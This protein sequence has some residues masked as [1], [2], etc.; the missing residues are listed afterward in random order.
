MK[1][2][3][4]IYLRLML[5]ALAWGT[6]FTSRAQVSYSTVSL[7]ASSFTAD[8]I[9]NGSASVAPGSVPTTGTNLP[10]DG[11][12]S[13]NYYY[14]S[15]DYNSSVG[16]HTAGLPNSGL[17]PNSLAG[18][19]ALTYQLAPYTGNNSL[20][21]VGS[22]TPTS[23]T[24][25][26]A[27]PTAAAEVYVLGVSGNGSSTA[28]MT[29]NY[30]DGTSTT[31]TNQSVPD[32]YNTSASTVPAA[33]VFGVTVR[34]NSNTAYTTAAA[35]TAPF[36][37]QIKLTIP[38]N[39]VTT[40]ITGVTFRNTTTST[41]VVMN[42][43]AIS[44]GTYPVCTVAPATQA[45]ATTTSGGSTALTTAC[46]STSI[47][48]S[49]TGMPVGT[50]GYTYQWQSSTTSATTGFSNISGATST[51]YTATGQSTATYYRAL[52]YC[53]Y[54]S[55]SGATPTPSGVV[56]VTQTPFNNCYCTPSAST[57]CGT[58]GIITSVAI[59]GTSFSHS[60]GCISSASPGYVSPYYANYTTAGTP[61]VTL[62]PGT[63]YTFTGSVGQ[64]TRV[65]VW[66]DYN[67]NGVFE[68]TEAT[69]IISNTTTSATTYSTAVAVP[70]GALTGNTRMRIR[71]ERNTTSVL[72]QAT[73]TA[74]CN[75]TTN[76]ES[77]DYLVT[78]S[79][80][81][82][83]AGTPPATTATSTATSV[84]GG[85]SFTLN[86]T[87]ITPGTTGLTYQWQSR[88]GTNA[89][90]N[91]GAAQ[92][93]PTYTV[94]SQTVATDYQV[95]VTCTASGQS[96]T[97][98]VVSV[99]QNSF[100]TC[101]CLPTYISGGANDNITN[102][103]LGTLANASTGNASPYY[104]DYTA[105]QNAVP[106][107]APG[108][109]ATV[110]VTFSTVDANQW[111]AVWID[112]DHSGTFDASEYFT[113]G[114]NAGAGGTA[115]ISITVPLAALAGQTRMR[116]R[117]GDD[118]QPTSGQ[119]CGA[120]LSNYGEGEDY[121]VNV[122]PS[123]AC[124]GTPPA[125]TAT[126]SAASVCTGTGFTLNATG[127]TPGTTGLTY[128]WQS[129]PAGANTFT[130]LGS[131]QTL[132]AY[133][134]S[135][136]AASTDYQV[137][138]T[139][140]AGGQ[141]V[142]SSVVSVTRTYLSCYCTP[143]SGATGEYIKNVTFPGISGFSSS[144]NLTAAPTS[145]YNGYSDFTASYNTTL[146][147][148]AT[149]QSGVSVTVHANN[150]G[151]QGGMWID[152]DHSGTFDAS[153][154]ISLGVSNLINTDVVLPVTLTV[155]TTALT[156]PTRVRVRWRNG[157]FANT[158][159]C[160]SGATTWYGETED[161]FIT[162]AAPATCTAPP[163]TILASASTTNACSNSSFTLATSSIPTTLGGFTFQWQS[164]PAGAGTF[165]D[166]SGATT[167]T[168]TVTSQ[169]AATDYLLIVSCQYG[170]TP[171]A[172]NIV[173]VG[174]N[175]FD[176]CYCTTS[177]TNGCSTYGSISNVNIGT[178][179]NSSTCAASTYTVYPAS[180]A[181]TNLNTGTSATLTLTVANASAGYR[182]GVW[183][184]FNQNGTFDASEFV[185]GS[186]PITT[187]TATLSIAIPT[188]ALA[189]ATRMRVR[190]KAGILS[191]GNFGATDACT[192][193]YDGETEDYTVTVVAPTPCNGTAATASAS[194]A[195]ACANT[196]FTLTGT[197][198]GNFTGVNYQWQSS[199]AG[200]NNFTDISG[201]TSLTYTV[202]DQTAAT[203]YQLLAT[204]AVG[205]VSVPS[206][207][208]TVG[209]SNFLNCYVTPIISTGNSEFIR[210]VS[211]NIGTGF[212][213]PTNASSTS[214]FGDFTTNSALTTT[215]SKGGN[216]P[217][218]IVVQSN[219]VGSQGGLWIDYDH[220]STFDAGEY[221]PFGGP[222]TA[223][224]QQ[225]TFSF[226]MLVPTTAAT[227]T[228]TTRMRVR[229]RN[230]TINATDG[231]TSGATAWYGETEDYLITID[232]SPLPVKLL[233]F[234]AEAEGSAVR[235]AWATASEQNS[236]HFEVERSADGQHFDF[237]GKV[238]AQGNTSSL[239]SYTFRDT[240]PT[241]EGNTRYYRLRQVDLD[242][243]AE[244]SPVRTV[245]L[246]GTAAT[247]SL[248]PNPA[249]SAVTVSG[250]AAGATVDVFD[251][252]GR[253]IST[254]VADATGTARLVLPAKLAAGMYVV[255]CGRLVSRLAVE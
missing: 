46:S 1:K 99:A 181:T 165:T 128:Q 236:S 33:N 55:G 243:S 223:G 225:L 138:V 5:L 235:L 226:R 253:L 125:T 28:D 95:V 254:T 43:F 93:L 10:I 116:I 69:T 241:G 239:S 70:A 25:T 91:L 207:V 237:I 135:S 185:A 227:L 62:A 101:Y 17:I 199:P 232:N 234:T 188:S 84:C 88:T 14:P 13:T 42:I 228:G 73:S 40:P 36:L 77:L 111:S 2:P 161:Y 206:N 12:A 92:A 105:T 238:N 4:T 230:S 119:A 174:Q 209:Q 83:C 153:E 85:T 246:S 193:Q 252:V 129:S 216:Y 148:G 200:Q 173:S 219:N 247:L 143:L 160:I 19:S 132:S 79:A 157:G 16:T 37:D 115:N 130:N 154:Y 7:A 180:T 229:W 68:S 89:F 147:Q 210:S 24:M 146:N 159:A 175:P 27:T 218:T 194:V 217:M 11:S 233:R 213:N 170:G 224:S 15:V 201:A 61:T 63:S 220:S 18:Y 110:Q 97:S 86:A 118:S 151:S 100:L 141:P 133:A 65:V 22:S 140:T 114:T 26:F 142:T 58:Y 72:T 9:A 41:S 156:G 189:G 164:S 202:P 203:D 39:K 184:D 124:T 81:V 103:V 50:I 78:I 120:S 98:S 71:S 35:N 215:L 94:A 245:Q 56:Q 242:G 96:T 51:T 136:I 198:P 211:I 187:A 123:V 178:L 3:F 231:Q 167:Q 20:R 248:V 168:Y 80:P 53:L 144:S 166:I 44:I 208:V 250:A 163:S 190:T 249:H 107:L 186:A 38:T 48:L 113:S 31:F 54:D 30:S 191:Y 162:I 82:A 127:I 240:N 34:V 131:A 176:Q 108:A 155:P 145:S 192:V 67:Q 196:P 169:T 74:A 66:I 152:Y 251:A 49:L 122:A 112:F 47:Y 102:V 204:C 139:C 60:P 64:G 121:L 109:S 150:T 195:A 8:V 214:G 197:M 117:G 59:T 75:V 23:G 255:R 45:V 137:I 177:S 171:V 158:D 29:V 87:G 52:V 212:S 182:Y 134:V 179:N 106:V 149:Y 57:G 90:A 221:F 21:I 244:Y 76:G 126:S 183:I 172:S 32:W 205:T 222:T 6:G 104:R